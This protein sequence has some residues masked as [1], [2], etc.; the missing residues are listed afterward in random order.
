MPP[1]IRSTVLLWMENRL[2]LLRGL[3]PLSP[4]RSSRPMVSNSQRHRN[5]S[6][7]NSSS[8]SNCMPP[9]PPDTRLFRR[10]FHHSNLTQT[11]RLPG[12]LA[13]RSSRISHHRLSN[14]SSSS[15]SIQMDPIFTSSSSSS[16]RS[17]STAPQ[18]TPALRSFSLPRMARILFFSMANVCR[19]LRPISLPVA[20]SFGPR[21]PVLHRT[22]TP[23]SFPSPPPTDRRRLLLSR[24]DHLLPTSLL[25]PLRHLLPPWRLRPNPPRTSTI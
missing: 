11:V 5:I 15:I 12:N 4:N 3:P 22:R 16:N 20:S 10:L 25:L 17:R 9:P 6:T 7:T 23:R 14:S 21:E 13:P 19:L 1:K 8:N 24:K 2:L 18:P